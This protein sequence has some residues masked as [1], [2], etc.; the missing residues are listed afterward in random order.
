MNEKSKIKISSAFFGSLILLSARKVVA[1]TYNFVSSSGLDKT[2]DNAGYSEALKKL[3]PAGV[4]ATVLLQVLTMLGVVF[5]GLVIYGG[6]TWITASGNEQRL[7]RAKDTVRTAII[8]LVVVLAAYAISYF[9][10]NYFSG[11][12]LN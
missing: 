10:I 4:A 8:G 11:T 5:I 2:S 1:Q 6:M 9:I 12:A 7:E 3:T